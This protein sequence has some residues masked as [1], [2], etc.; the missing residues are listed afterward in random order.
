M[1]NKALTEFI[2]STEGLTAT[3]DCLSH[4]REKDTNVFQTQ[5]KNCV[6]LLSTDVE[7][8]QMRSQW[9]HKIIC[10]HP[11]LS[12]QTTGILCPVM[13]VK[14][15]DTAPLGNTC[16]AALS[17]L[18]LKASGL[19]LDVLENYSVSQVASELKLQEYGKGT[20][21]TFKMMITR[22]NNHSYRIDSWFA[23][24]LKGMPLVQ[25]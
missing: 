4:M 22:A 20:H 6:H 24:Y 8:I 5:S 13:V 11:E 25:R 15:K 7:N 3:L 14:T 16:V 12:L 2:T 10:Q 1:S 21:N 9:G 18:I 17:A 19:P 23:A